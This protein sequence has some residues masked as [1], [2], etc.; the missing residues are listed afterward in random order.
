MT[1]YTTEQPPEQPSEK[2]SIGLLVTAIVGAVVVAFIV[3]NS[4]DVP[5]KFMGISRSLP[6]WLVIAVAVLFGMALSWALGVVRR[7]GKRNRSRQ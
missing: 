7:R 5:V 4:H 2:F 1:D 3:S 6:L